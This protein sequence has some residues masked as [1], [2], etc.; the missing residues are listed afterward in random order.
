MGEKIKEACKAIRAQ[1]RNRR[2]RPRAPRPL[3]TDFQHWAETWAPPLPPPPP[4]PP[5]RRQQEKKPLKRSDVALIRDWIT[6][7]QGTERR[8]GGPRRAADKPPKDAFKGQCLEAH[9]GLTKAQSSV[10]VQLR[11]GKIGLGAFLYYRKVPDQFS[12]ICPCGQGPQTPEH[13]F[14]QCTEQ[15]SR[16]MRRMGYRS[17]QEFWA[18]LYDPK[19][20]KEITTT[21]LQSGWLREYRLAEQLREEEGLALAKEG[22]EKPPP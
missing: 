7:W 6:K 18:G 10:L 11:T 5:G 17:A 21:I 4:P 22:W 20:G 16:E 12:P 3:A 14:T 19:K 13:L 8:G 2:G 1:L 9:G 15:R